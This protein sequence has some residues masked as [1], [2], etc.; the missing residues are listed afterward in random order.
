VD[1]AV[2]VDAPLALG[3]LDAPAPAPALVPVADVDVPA[4]VP[5]ALPVGDAV[6][7]A[8]TVVVVAGT[9]GAAVTLGVGSGTDKET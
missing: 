5:V 9:A 7:A 3:A 1:V 8:G 2:A 6:D 4:P